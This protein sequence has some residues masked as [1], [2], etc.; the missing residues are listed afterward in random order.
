MKRLPR[1]WLPILFIRLASQPLLDPLV[2]P[3]HRSFGA[4][5]LGADLR[6]RM[7]LQAKNQNL[8]RTPREL[9]QQIFN[10]L[11][12]HCCLRWRRFAIVEFRGSSFAG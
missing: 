1:R 7:A 8:S 2:G 4:A 11:S 6:R 10:R 9:L 3:V 5:D 12:Q